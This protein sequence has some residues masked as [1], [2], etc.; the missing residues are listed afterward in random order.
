MEYLPNL[1]FQ[2]IEIFFICLLWWT[3]LPAVEG[4]LLSKKYD[5]SLLCNRKFWA[6]YV[7][8][9]LVWCQM[10]KRLIIRR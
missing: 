7:M 1:P 4:L 10:L 2:L 9:S 8:F 5:F 3:V 6:L